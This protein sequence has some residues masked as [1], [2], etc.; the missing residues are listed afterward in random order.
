MVSGSIAMSHRQARTAQKDNISQVSALTMHLTFFQ[1][2]KC[3]TI[4]TVRRRRSGMQPLN[5]NILTT[6]LAVTIFF[7]V[8]VVDAAVN[9]ASN[10][11]F[12]E[13]NSENTNPE[14][15]LIYFKLARDLYDNN[16]YEY[17]DEL[18][19]KRIKELSK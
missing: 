8:K 7:A 15:A 10:T 3:L 6:S 2:C 11:L 19:K 9:F 12:V 18:S 16:Y 5:T 1:F 13:Y 4:E 14:K 17:I